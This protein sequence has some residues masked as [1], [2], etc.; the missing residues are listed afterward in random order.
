MQQ[1]LPVTLRDFLQNSVSYQVCIAHDSTAAKT[2][3]HALSLG[4]ASRVPQQGA[5][6]PFIVPG[7]TTGI[8]VTEQNCN[9]DVSEH[10]GAYITA[11]LS[12]HLCSARTVVPL[13]TNPYKSFFCAIK[14][15]LCLIHSRRPTLLGNCAYMSHIKLLWFVFCEGRLLFGHILPSGATDHDDKFSLIF[16]SR[17]ADSY[18]SAYLLG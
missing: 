16:E 2:T 18:A 10:Q 12:D 9:D 11:Y 6:A 13:A 14:Y 4:L 8:P 5:D 3:L 1:V 7:V 17:L 15:L